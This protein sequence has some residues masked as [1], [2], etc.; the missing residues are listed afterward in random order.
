MGEIDSGTVME[1]SANL[2]LPLVQWQDDSHGAGL[3]WGLPR[4]TRAHG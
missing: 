1:N 4:A 3:F 2:P